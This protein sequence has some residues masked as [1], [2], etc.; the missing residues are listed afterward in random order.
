MCRRTGFW[1]TFDVFTPIKLDKWCWTISKLQR[2]APKRLVVLVRQHSRRVTF[3]IPC[4]KERIWGMNSDQWTFGWISECS[5]IS[6]WPTADTDA[7]VLWAPAQL[8]EQF[9]VGIQCCSPRS[10]TSTSDSF[11]WDQYGAASLRFWRTFFSLYLAW[12]PYNVL[13]ADYSFHAQ[14][15]KERPINSSHVA[16]VSSYIVATS[17]KGFF[18]AC[19]WAPCI[20]WWRCQIKHKL[21]ITVIWCQSTPPCIR[22]PRRIDRFSMA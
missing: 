17:A 12:S 7:W 10:K 4:C 16:N 19:L 22:Q 6:F 18:V 8:Q 2:D 3:E 15:C 5:L 11:A 9:W 13:Q 20:F 1:K 14:A 21:V